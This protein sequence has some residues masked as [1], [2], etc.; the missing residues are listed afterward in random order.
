M[1][2]A[3]AF[4]RG[5]D[6]PG[7]FVLLAVVASLVG[8]AAGLL[9]VLLLTRSADVY[10]SGVAA[11]YLLAG[12][13]GLLLVARSG[14]IRLTWRGVRDALGVGAPTVP[15]QVSLYLA[16]A[17]LV[18]VADRVLGDG[19][20]ANV[21]LTIGAGATVVTAGLNNAWAPVVYRAAPAD[22]GRVLDETSRAIA[23]VTVVLAGGVALLAP[24]LVRLAA[25]ASYLPH[26]LV[27]AVALACA[28]AFP[29]V[30]YLASGHL[31]FARGRTGWLALSTP[32]AVGCGLAAAAGLA[33]AWG[34]AGI[35][36]AYLLTYLLLAL[37]TTVVQRKVAE[38]PW[39][40]P[41]MP[42]VVALWIALGVAGAALPVSGAVATVRV[43]VAALLAVAGVLAL[44]R[45]RG[46]GSAG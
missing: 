36:G 23:L 33:S 34:I 19:G 1:V 22:R 6:R 35:G 30:V 13:L 43:A 31:V 26:E 46:A 4:L 29:S 40:P 38:H 32:L 17:G 7:P 20:R 15:H 14:E 18:V 37:G 2:L 25:P 5:A 10:L 27:P 44:R 41:V 16:L 9:A 42:A 24:W 39:W 28:A 8:P 45:R 3:Q 11:G 12:A 21:A